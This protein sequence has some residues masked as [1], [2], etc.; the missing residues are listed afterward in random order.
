MACRSEWHTPVALIL[1]VTSPGPGGGHLDV[2]DDLELLVT[3]V[4]EHCCTHGVTL[5]VG[6]R[7]EAACNGQARRRVGPANWNAF[8]FCAYDLPRMTDHRILEAGRSGPRPAGAGRPARA[9]S[10]RAG[11]LLGRANQVG[12][13]PARP[14]AS[15]RAT[16][17]AVLLPNGTELIELYLGA[18]QIGRLPHADQPP[19]GRARDRLHRRRQRRQGLRRPRALRRRGHARRGRRGRLPRRPPLRR[20]HR[21]T[22]SAPTPSC[23]TGQPTTAARGPH[24]RRGD[25]LHVGHHRPAQGREAGPRRAS[26]PTTWPSSMTLPAEPVRHRPRRRPRPPHR[27]RRS[28]T[29]RC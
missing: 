6:A 25:A 20:R 11:E 13:R 4:A 19:P 3:G 7:L 29:P 8:Q 27:A 16:P 1:I 22:A 28:T 10:T 21:S 23:S 12:P 17:L 14:R 15:R 2:V 5:D 18:L 9:A 26:T 24:H